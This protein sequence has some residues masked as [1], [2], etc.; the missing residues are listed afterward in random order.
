[1][2]PKQKAGDIL[3]KCFCACLRF[4]HPKDSFKSISLS[5]P[6]GN[7]LFFFFYFALVFCPFSPFLSLSSYNSPA[8]LWAL[9]WLSDELDN[10]IWK[11][12]QR[13]QIKPLEKTISICFAFC[14]CLITLWGEMLPSKK[15]RDVG[16]NVFSWL[17][18]TLKASNRYLIG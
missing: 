5:N 11:T 9:D 14:C 4:S 12:I 10:W 3:L 1:M 15:K 16:V 18:K 8:L 7:C 6:L 13:T 17:I 2:W